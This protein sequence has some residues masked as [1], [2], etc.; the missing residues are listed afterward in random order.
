MDDLEK[1]FRH[2]SSGHK[3]YH[4]RLSDFIIFFDK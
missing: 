4:K 3:K 2:T 1:K